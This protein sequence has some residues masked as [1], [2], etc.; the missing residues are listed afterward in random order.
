MSSRPERHAN[1]VSSRNS[2]AKWRDPEKVSATLLLWE[3]LPKQPVARPQPKKKIRYIRGISSSTLAIA[4]RM[5]SGD[6]TVKVRTRSGR[7]I[8]STFLLP[9]AAALKSYWR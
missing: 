6:R 7:S 8:F 3:V 4:W 5:L 2:S 1:L 9:R